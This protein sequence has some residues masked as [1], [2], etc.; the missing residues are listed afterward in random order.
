MIV[1]ADW[2]YEQLQKHIK[3]TEKSLKEGEAIEVLYLI[4]SGGALL[5]TD[6]G[7]HNPNMII[8]YALDT[9]GQKCKVL[10]HMASLQLLIK[11]VPVKQEEAKRT[12]GFLGG[13]H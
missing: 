12:I 4:P 6:I 9:E 1:L 10:A 8:L 2:F 13:Q 11:N 5:V 3:E 7:Y